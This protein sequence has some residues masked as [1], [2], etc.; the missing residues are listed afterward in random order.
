MSST[1]PSKKSGGINLFE[2]LVN[3][4]ARS[5]QATTRGTVNAKTH[6]SVPVD[7]VDVIHESCTRYYHKIVPIIYD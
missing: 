6:S 7:G 1:K 2:L 3:S 5:V 4:T